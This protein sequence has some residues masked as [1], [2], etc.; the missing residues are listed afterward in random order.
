MW[1][2]AVPNIEGAEYI[3]AYETVSLNREEF[4]GQTVL[5]LGQD[6]YWLNMLTIKITIPHE[7]SV[8]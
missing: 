4:E 6:V 3:E 7:T 8:Q 1:Q 5:I 2:P